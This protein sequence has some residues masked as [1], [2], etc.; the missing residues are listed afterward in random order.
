MKIQK[1]KAAKISHSLKMESGSFAL[2]NKNKI[3]ISLGTLI[4][5]LR[6][7]P[8]KITQTTSKQLKPIHC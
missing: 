8:T 4:S 6:E 7:V 1:N 5:K 3:I 2:K